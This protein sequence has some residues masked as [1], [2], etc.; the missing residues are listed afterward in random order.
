MRS[1]KPILTDEERRARAVD[2]AAIRLAATAA[3]ARR[4]HSIEDLRRKLAG[5]GFDATAVSAVIQGMAEK[6]L[7]SNQRF[8]TS[9]VTYHAARGQ[10][11]VRIRAELRSHGIPEQAIESAF[12]SVDVDWAGIARAVRRK[13]FGEAVP[14]AMGERAKQSRFLQYRGFGSDDVRAAFV[15]GSATDINV[16]FDAD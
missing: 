3:L 7:I 15:V 1:L 5:K 9:F 11:P 6:G 16:E 10:G 8:T 14:R 12:K 13:R 4:E 2:E